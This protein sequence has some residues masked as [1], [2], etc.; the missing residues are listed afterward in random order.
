M[1]MQLM[2]STTSSAK[3]VPGAK[4]PAGK[5]PITRKQILMLAAVA[6]A[7]ALVV[8]VWYL[9]KLT[10]PTL[11]RMNEPTA[12]LAI[13]TNTPFF[14]EQIFDIQAQYMKELDRRNEKEKDEIDNAFKA[15]QLT[16]A[17]YRKALQMAW[18]GKHLA[19]VEKYYSMTG[20]PRQQY[21]D[22]LIVKKFKED[23]EEAKNPKPPKEISG[24]PTGAEEKARIEK[25]PAEARERWEGF[26][27]AYKDRKKDVEKMRAKTRP[28]V[29]R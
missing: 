20:P 29:A 2:T 16:E 15:G 14:E 7:I 17:E 1:R 12:K 11:P 28:A 19:R 18:F 25:W 27:K 3:G 23:E 24:N 10:K 6:G 8:G 21:L 22:E 5:Q 26:E 13:F 4:T 9:W